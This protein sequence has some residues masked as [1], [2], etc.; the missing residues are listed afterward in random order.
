MPHPDMEIQMG[1][2]WKNIYDIVNIREISQMDNRYNTLFIDAIVN[3]G[4]E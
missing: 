4:Q 2:K 1:D 3:F